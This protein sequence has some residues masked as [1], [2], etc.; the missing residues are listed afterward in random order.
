MASCT[1]DIG[2]APRELQQSEAK[3]LYM[4]ALS[5]SYIKLGV[6]KLSV[7]IKYK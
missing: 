5:Y 2:G 6:K 4:K 1:K 3:L 7:K